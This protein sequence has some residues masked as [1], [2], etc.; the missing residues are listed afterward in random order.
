M[1]FLTK[2]KLLPFLLT[3]GIILADQ[4]VKLFIVKN[5]PLAGGHGTFI[6][7]VFDNDFLWIYHV[8]N[9][10]IAFSL[11]DTLPEFIR[12]VLF[13]FTPLILLGGLVG[14]YFKST[15][16]TA[17]QR[18]VLAGIIGGGLGNLIDRIFRPEGVVDFISVKFYGLF[19]LERWPTFN[20]A[21][22]SVVVSCMVLFLSIL[23]TKTPSGENLHE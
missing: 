20:I 22:A 9:R 7:D 12:P 21:D 15:E 18:W 3:A 19:G 5:W 10:A 17:L 14:Y 4:G 2:N 16:I 23:F 8:R 11:G 13:I 1:K 6:K